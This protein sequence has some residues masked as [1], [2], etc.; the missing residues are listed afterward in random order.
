MH[1]KCST[2]PTIKEM[3][4]KT[5]LFPSYVRKHGNHQEIKKINAGMAAVKTELSYIIGGNVN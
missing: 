5:M 4:I 1:R 3:H 2:S